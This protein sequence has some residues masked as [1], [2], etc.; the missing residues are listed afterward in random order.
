MLVFISNSFCGGTVKKIDSKHSLV[1]DMNRL[2][3]KDE[4]EKGGVKAGVGM[5][6]CLELSQHIHGLL[7]CDSSYKVHCTLILHNQNSHLD[8]KLRESRNWLI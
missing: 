7:N 2:V 1:L 6:L 3:K 4:K 8:R 5:L